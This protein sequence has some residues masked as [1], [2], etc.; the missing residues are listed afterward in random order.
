MRITNK[1]MTNNMMSNINKNKLNM[2]TLEEQYSSGKKIQRPSDDPIITVRALKL[3]TN[4]SELSQYYEKNIPDAQSWMD[5]TESALTTVNDVLKQIN[6]YCVQGSSDT[7]T[8][9]DRSSIAQNLEQM[10]QQ[11]YQE[12]NTNYAGRYV[13]TGYKTDSSLIFSED[14][15]YLTYNITQDFTGDDLQVVNK[16]SGSYDIEDYDDSATDFSE[17]PKLNE[18]YRIQLA[19]DKLSTDAPTSISYFKEDSSGILTEQT[20]I[21]SNINSISSTD[22]EAYTPDADEIHY[23]PETGEVIMGADVYKELRTANK[24]EMQYQKTG[25]ESGSLKPEHYFTCTMTDGDKPEQGDITY[26]KSEEG[27]DIQYEVNYNQKIKVNTEG[28]DAITHQI[29]RSIEDILATVNEVTDTESKI[30]EVKKRLADTTLSDEE[31][32]RYNKLKDQLDTEL[33]LKKEAMQKAFEKGITTS[34]EGQDKVNAAVADLGSRA[35]RLELTEN[36][37]SSQKVDFE[38][39][40]SKNEDADLVETYI[41]YGSAETVYNSSLSAAAKIIKNSLLDFL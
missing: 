32:T 21:S 12:G 31:I 3:R 6:T 13:F 14:M 41:K 16:V 27:Q 15:D 5:V 23:I 8:A 40:L 26:T 35:V 25:F 34:S 2:T 1:M 4:L 18:V 7:L 33:D 30:A 20:P 29:G 28:S 9:S 37:L 19:Y 36:R 17:S 38:D 11:I 22:P 24:I 39:L 10:K